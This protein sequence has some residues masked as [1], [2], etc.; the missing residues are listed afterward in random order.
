MLTVTRAEFSIPRL[1]APSTRRNRLLL[2]EVRRKHG[3]LEM[4]QLS[5]STFRLPTRPPAAIMITVSM[6]IVTS[7]LMDNMLTQANGRRETLMIQLSINQRSKKMKRK[8]ERERLLLH[9]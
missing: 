6:D 4:Q 8:H 3:H 1:E 5:V 7:P 2:A 9:T